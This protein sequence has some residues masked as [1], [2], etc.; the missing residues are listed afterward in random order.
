MPVRRVF[1]RGSCLAGLRVAVATAAP[2]A[3]LELQYEVPRSCPSKA[4][5]E[6]AILRMLGASALGTRSIQATIR[7]EQLA[8]DQFQ[9]VL[10]THSDGH[11]G[12]RAI[13]G[14]SCDSVVEAAAI[15]VAL[16][17]N[18]DVDRPPQDGAEGSVAPRQSSVGSA[19]HPLTAREEAPHADAVSS[20]SKAAPTFT[21]ETDPWHWAVAGA[22][23]IHLGI[24]PHPGPEFSGAVSLR[25]R[26]SQLSLSAAYAPPQSVPLAESAGTGGNLWHGSVTFLGCQAV[27][28][29]VSWISPCAGLSMVH[30]QGTGY[31]VPVAHTASTEWLAPVFG[32]QSRAPLSPRAHLFAAGLL[33]VP[34]ARPRTYLDDLG[35]LQQPAPVTARLALGAA[36]DWM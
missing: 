13:E 36:F 33:E 18:P 24:E 9:L 19:P 25:N 29:S 31:G 28:R 27:A 32:V 34:L 26:L 2:A 3:P 6:S 12:E 30:V 7:V 35:G 15:T 23:G 20:R 14:N 11:R 1:W 10:T 5:F 16:I 21:R 4:A 8:A 22:V 17:L